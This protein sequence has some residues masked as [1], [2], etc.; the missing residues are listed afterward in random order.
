MMMEARRWLEE[1][2]IIRNASSYGARDMSDRVSTLT[3]D[4]VLHG[5]GKCPG[6]LEWMHSRP[7]G[8]SEKP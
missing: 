3:E 4:V 7:P 5:H 8:T 6:L 1:G 2:A